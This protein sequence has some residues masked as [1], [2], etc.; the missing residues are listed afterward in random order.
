MVIISSS[1]IF[2]KNDGGALFSSGS[3]LLGSWDGF[4]L[5]LGS[6]R[7]MVEMHRYK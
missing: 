2:P 5:W 1:P 6:A 3:T 4:F 7:A